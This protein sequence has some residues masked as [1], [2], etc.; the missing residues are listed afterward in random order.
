MDQ[1][2]FKTTELADRI[3]DAKNALIRLYKTNGH[4]DVAAAL[5]DELSKIEE[6]KKIRVVFIGQ[7]TAG[8]ST[9]IS[10]LTGNRSI[11]IDSDIATSVSSDSF[12][13]SF[14]VPNTMM[15]K[16]KKQ[17]MAIASLLLVVIK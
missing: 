9:I 10:A 3:E 13:L 6:E 17:V 1:I 16:Q 2:S 12:S 4:D 5:N 11:K 15:R 8:K 7:Y 14:P